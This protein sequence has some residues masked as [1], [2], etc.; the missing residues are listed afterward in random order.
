MEY[1][2]YIFARI[3]IYIQGC[4]FTL[5]VTSG[6]ALSL[7]RLKPLSLQNWQR[8]PLEKQYEGY[9]YLDSKQLE[10]ILSI[11]TGF[12]LH[13]C[14]YIVIHKIGDVRQ[15]KFNIFFNP[16][17]TGRVQ[18]CP[19][20]FI[21]SFISKIFPRNIVKLYVNS[22]FI[23]MKTLIIYFGHKYCLA[24][25]HEAPK[26]FKLFTILQRKYAR[27]FYPYLLN[28]NALQNQNSL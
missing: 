28:K 24:Q 26:N 12:I 19:S 16:I 25:Q 15:I 9:S 1:L 20:I 5:L 17:H 14:T 21:S 3:Y 7:Q 6:F 2:P 23:L 11:F 8:L 22:Y 18:I 10:S 4:I 13:L 27:Y